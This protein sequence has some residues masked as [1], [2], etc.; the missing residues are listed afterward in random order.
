[1][2]C[3]TAAAACFIRIVVGFSFMCILLAPTAIAPDETR[4]TSWPIFWMSERTMAN[5]SIVRRLLLPSSFVR[6]DSVSFHYRSFHCAFLCRAARSRCSFVENDDRRAGIHRFINLLCRPERKVYA[7][8]G[9]VS[10]V[11]I[12]AKIVSPGRVVKPLSFVEGHPVLDLLFI[13]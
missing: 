12:A 6:V 7:S 8:V 13:S 11:N 4:M 1:M 9:S 5:F 10:S 3:P 2:H